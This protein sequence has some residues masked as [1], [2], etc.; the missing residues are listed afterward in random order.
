MEHKAN[1]TWD[2]A[3]FLLNNGKG[4]S[5][6]QRLYYSAFQAVHGFAQKK[7]LWTPGHKKGKHEVAKAIVKEHLRDCSVAYNMLFGLRVKADYTPE[8]VRVDEVTTH[9]IAR[10]KSVREY[11]CNQGK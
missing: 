9:L 1:L 7:G 8:E 6:A 5:G 10:A 3:N 11:F 4:N 2:E